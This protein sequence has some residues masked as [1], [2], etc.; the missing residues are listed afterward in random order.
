VETLQVKGEEPAGE[1]GEESIATARRVPFAACD[2]PE[3]G[4]R[5][6]AA[7]EGDDGGGAA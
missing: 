5:D 4:E 6:Y 1:Y 7:E 3:E 2:E